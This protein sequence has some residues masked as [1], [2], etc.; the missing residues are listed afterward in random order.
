MLEAK[1][2]AAGLAILS[3]TPSLIN[4]FGLLPNI[5]FPTLG[6][7]FFWNDIAEANGWRV[8]RNN[9]TGHCRILDSDDVRRA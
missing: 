6:G 3:Q 9:I 5:N 8:Q 4:K 2:L 1:V 7:S